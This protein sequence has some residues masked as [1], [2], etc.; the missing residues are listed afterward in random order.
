MEP[1]IKMILREVDKEWK[2]IKMRA[3]AINAKIEID[4]DNGYTIILTRKAF[5]G[6][7]MFV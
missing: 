1:K 3:A 2:N 6:T 5:S 7:H 4:K